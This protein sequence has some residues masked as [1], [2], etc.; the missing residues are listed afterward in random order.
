MREFFIKGDY[1]NIIELLF[2]IKKLFCMQ[3]S[4]HPKNKRLYSN[5]LYKASAKTFYTHYF[6]K[7]FARYK[8]SWKDKNNVYTL[9]SSLRF[10]DFEG[11]RPKLPSFKYL[12]S[13]IS[14]YIESR[15]NFIL[16]TPVPFIVFEAI[17]KLNEILSPSDR[18]L[19]IGSGNST[20][21]FLKKQCKIVSIEHSKIW[22]DVLKNHIDT[23]KFDKK[24]INNISIHN[25]SN[26][27]T[28]KLIGN[29]N[30]ESFD[31]ILIDGANE[32]NNRNECIARSLSK[33]KKGGWIVLDNSDHPNNWPGSI[34]LDSK[35]KRIRFTG[36]AP[37]G[38][39]VTQ[40][41]FW[42]KTD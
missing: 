23:I 13:A 4:V 19:E 15:K 7:L 38:L 20:L 22:Y 42:Q 25:S 21:W 8:V 6:D 1:K 16:R 12:F 31:L 14:T 41:S 37:M 34:Y 2:L 33:L 28:W 32:F 27:D 24:T 18:V 17:N 36:F 11:F 40:T 29:M 5:V 30:N 9:K 3:I 26:E 35:Y 10:K 39:Y